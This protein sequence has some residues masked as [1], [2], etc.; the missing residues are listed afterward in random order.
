MSERRILIARIIGAFGVSGEMKC[1][2]FADPPAQVFKYS[3]LILVHNG[4]EQTIE[5][6]GGRMTAKGPVIR[7]PEVSDRDVA[8]AMH[9][10]ELWVLRRQL[11]KPA[12]GEYY[13]AD[14]EGLR[15][16]NREGVD[17]GTVSHLFETPGNAVMVVAGERE[18]LIPF[19]L[20]RFVDSV[21]IEAG[22]IVVDWDADF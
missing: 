16:R 6:V 13:W 7:L 5:R 11:P 18:R 1:Q 20:D 21:D 4:Q 3:P 22:L 17:F 2:S 9:G 15:V 14:L 19:L 8:Q 12:P 10:A